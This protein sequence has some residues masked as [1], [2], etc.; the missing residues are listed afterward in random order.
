M[1]RFGV[2]IIHVAFDLAEQGRR[3]ENVDWHLP[4]AG[5]TCQIIVRFKVKKI[6]FIK[7]GSA[8]DADKWNETAAEIDKLLI[9]GDHA[10]GREFSFS[11][12]PVKGFW[13]GKNSGVQICPPPPNAPLPNTPAGDNPFILEFPIKLSGN[14]IVDRHRRIKQHQSLTLVLNLFLNR[15]ISFQQQRRGHFWAQ[16]PIKDGLFEFKW[17]HQWYFADLGEIF[18]SSLSP[19]NS[20]MIDV[21]QAAKYN[22]PET[23]V[24]D[25]LTVPD[26]L[27]DLL[28]CYQRLSANSLEKFDRAA[29]WFDLAFR[30]W[31]I[32]ASASFTSLV[33]AIETFTGS[34]E[35][36]KV[37]CAECGKDYQH[38]APGLTERFR[39]F[40]EKYAS[41]VALRTRR[42]QMYSLRSN[43]LH[44]RN[45]MQ[46]DQG[47]DFGWDPPGRNEYELHAELWKLTQI[48]MRNWLKASPTT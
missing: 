6:N 18:T 42:S 46:S 41:G 36:H 16:V 31:E 30:Q 34:G 4:L 15:R 17:L 10:I 21:I 2:G 43:I 38:E 7:R 3:T 9:D 47:H 45:L 26:D 29:F 13:R 27:D 44:G 20:Q 14:S 1:L 8:F 19:A 5:E 37:Q 35:I 33:S 22:S 23:L 32:A 25:L 39:E 48:A 40:F 24:G 12:G 28:W 11:K